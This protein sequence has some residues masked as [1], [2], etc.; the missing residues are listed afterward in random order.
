MANL[1]GGR[2]FRTDLPH[3]PLSVIHILIRVHVTMTT[4]V[5]MVTVIVMILHH[6]RPQIVNN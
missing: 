1:V 6:Q 4:R 2:L 3:T 5:T